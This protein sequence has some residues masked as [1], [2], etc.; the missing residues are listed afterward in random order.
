MK[1]VFLRGYGI[2]PC[3]VYF[4]SLGLPSLRGALQERF[5]VRLKHF[6]NTCVNV[7]F[8]FIRLSGLR[9]VGHYWS[10]FIRYCW[11]HGL[12]VRPRRVLLSWAAARVKR[13]SLRATL[14]QEYLYVASR[15]F[16]CVEYC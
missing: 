7:F 1:E 4:F 13:P 8:I 16:L 5:Y 14:L 12:G 3:T 2:V 6:S 11:L 9:F 15:V 10:I